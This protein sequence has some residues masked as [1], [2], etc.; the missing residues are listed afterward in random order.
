P[1]AYESAIAANVDQGILDLFIASAMKLD[2]AWYSEF[3]GISRGDQHRMEVDCA[4]AL[5]PQLESLLVKLDVQEYIT[6]PIVSDRS[7]NA[8]VNSLQTLGYAEEQEPWVS[9]HL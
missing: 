1:P 6:A 7:W 9:S 4:M 5:L 2:P 8:F 3:A